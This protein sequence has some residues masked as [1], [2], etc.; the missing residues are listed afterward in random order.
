[1]AAANAVAEILDL[2]G[3]IPVLQAGEGWRVDRPDSLTAIAVAL[4]AGGRI[5]KLRTC[6]GSPEALGSYRSVPQH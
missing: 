4:R 1:M 6:S 3:E 5:E 2:R